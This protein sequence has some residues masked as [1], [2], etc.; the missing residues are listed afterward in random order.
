MKRYYYKLRIA[1]YIRAYG[2]IRCSADISKMF[3]EAQHLISRVFDNLNG[4]RGVFSDM[5]PGT[6][7]ENSGFCSRI[8]TVSG[9]LAD[10]GI[11]LT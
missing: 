11:D 8:T 5:I 1:K 6:F 3:T 7:P 4:M 2:C 9:T 10:R